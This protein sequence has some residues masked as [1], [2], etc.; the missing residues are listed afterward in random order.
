MNGMNSGDDG[1]PRIQLNYIGLF[2]PDANFKSKKQEEVDK[3][4]EADK[5]AKEL[6][7]AE[8]KAKEKADA[9]K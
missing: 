8:Q 7:E 1:I 9:E 2:V 4:A 5:K 6:A 3:Q